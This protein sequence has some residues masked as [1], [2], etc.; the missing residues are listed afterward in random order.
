MKIDSVSKMY[1]GESNVNTFLCCKHEQNWFG[2]KNA[3][4]IEP[5]I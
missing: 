1:N 5:K 3:T 2:W 4:K